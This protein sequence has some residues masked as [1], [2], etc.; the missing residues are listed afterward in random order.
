[1]VDP[2]LSGSRQQIAEWQ[3]LGYV[4]E[5]AD[6]LTFDVLE[7]HLDEIIPHLV[8]CQRDGGSLIRREPGEP[9]VVVEG[10][11]TEKIR[12]VHLV[13]RPDGW[14]IEGFAT[15]EEVADAPGAL[16]E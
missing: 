1:M 14:R 13:R 12:E 10:G 8:I 4:T 9:D 11:Y 6:T 3:A 7:T 16:C 2:Q 5:G 15:R